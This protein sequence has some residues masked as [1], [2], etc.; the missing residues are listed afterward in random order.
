M[1]LVNETAMDSYDSITLVVSRDSA[2]SK[3]TLLLP[4][5]FETFE[6]I[7]LDTFYYLKA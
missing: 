3:S 7:S 5:L 1:N 4:S 2:E 6:N